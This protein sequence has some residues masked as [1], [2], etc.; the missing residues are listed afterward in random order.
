[1]CH[2]TLQ[3]LLLRLVSLLDISEL[4]FNHLLL[5]VKLALRTCFD[6]SLRLVLLLLITITHLAHFLPRLLFVLPLSFAHFLL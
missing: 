3:I 4:I 5:A 1:M 6:L 2:V